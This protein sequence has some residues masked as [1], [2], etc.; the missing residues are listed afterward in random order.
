MID[1]INQ[2]TAKYNAKAKAIEQKML[3]VKQQYV[4]NTFDDILKWN[5]AGQNPITTA[6][7]MLMFGLFC[8]KFLKKK[9]IQAKQPEYLS[10]GYSSPRTSSTFHQPGEFVFT[11]KAGKMAFERYFKDKQ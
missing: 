5:D 4:I 8:S 6:Y 2:Q 11:P 7:R 9:P 1:I 3:I 10:G